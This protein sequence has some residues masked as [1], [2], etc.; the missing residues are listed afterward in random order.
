MAGSALGKDSVSGFTFVPAPPAI[1][2]FSP[3]TGGAGTVVTISGSGFTG[4]T[5]VSFGGTAAASFTVN[6]ATSITAVLGAGATGTVSVTTPNGTTSYGTFTFLDPPK[7]VSFSPASGSTGDTLTIKG[8]YLTNSTAVTLGGVAAASYVVAS[9]TTIYAVVGT[10]ASGY[11][12]VVSALGNDSASGFTFVSTPPPPPPPPPP[13][14]FQLVSFT[15]TEVASHALLQWSVAHDSSIAYYV[16]QYSSDSVTF[17]PM[18]SLKAKQAD[19]ATYVFSDPQHFSGT[20]YYQLKIEDTADK[21]MF[22]PVIVVRMGGTPATLAVYP[23]PASESFV[24]TVPTTTK[25]SKF[26]LVDMSGNI[27]LTAQ[28][29]VGTNQVTINVG[30]MTRGVYK[31]I[32]TDG[33]NSSYQTVLIIR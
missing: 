2:T 32:W 1:T 21:A 22:S 14:G 28:V 29:S 27:A 31:L 9:D 4:A 25:N 13:A 19:S 8:D 11:V 26:E 18:E 3:A 7:I 10:G 5:V 12:V 30:T 33:T 6:S 24:V 15:G 16:V 17:T 23:N 20:N